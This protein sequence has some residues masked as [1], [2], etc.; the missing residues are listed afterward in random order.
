MRVSRS[1]FYKWFSGA[2]SKREVT[3]EQLKVEIEKIYRS[4]KKTYG[5]RRV[6]ATLRHQFIKC[7]KNRAA[8]IMTRLG[9][10][11]I[12]KRKFKRTT[13]SDHNCPICPNL[14]VQDFQTLSANILWTSDITYVPTK[15]GWLYLCIVLDTFSRAIVG[16][17]M[18]DTMKSELVLNAIEMAVIFRKPSPGVIFHSDRGS[19]Y[20]S[21]AVKR[22]L[23][24]NRFH[25]SM[26]STG[27]CYDNAISETFF[28]TLKK[29]LIHRCDFYTRKE[30]K[31][32]IFE[33]IEV[34]YNRLRCHSALGFVSPME[35]ELRNMKS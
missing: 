13:N 35:Y 12:G 24:K 19:Q 18:S 10:Q 3:D 1:G 25:Q 11:G 15:E 16:W 6:H 21:L 14:I 32:A 5:R 4:S 23:K 33:F 31:S 28:A 8:K 17:S 20:A 2:R 7:G 22:A 34:F 30:A 27:N 9:I 26:S 29:E